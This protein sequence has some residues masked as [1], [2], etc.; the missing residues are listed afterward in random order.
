MR[1][2][3]IHNQVK[4]H[5][6]RVVVVCADDET[7][8]T[9]LAEASQEHIIEPF[10]TG[11]P[12]RIFP[13]LATLGLEQWREKILPSA[14]P[15][16]AAA[17]AFQMVARGEAELVMKGHVPTPLLLKAALRQE[18]GFTTG[19]LL[20]HVAFFEIPGLEKLLCLTDTGMVLRPTFEE[21]ISLIDNA[22]AFE[23]TLGIER[24][25]VAIVS[26]TETP[27]PKMQCSMDA[28]ELM[29]LA[30]AGRFP[31]ADIWGPVDVSIAL[32]PEAAAIKGVPP[33]FSGKTDIWLVPEM[34]GGNI[35][36]KTLIY[37]AKAAAGGVI[38]G[39]KS[40]IILLSRASAPSEKF[41]SIVLAVASCK[42]RE[43]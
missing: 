16:Q 31:N 1:F 15:E 17:A 27:N 39:G 12:A 10:L 42:R 8:L 3:D 13:L 25:V 38:V 18:N 30:Q 22:V 35:L 4:N 36:G 29:K 7:A 9:A 37:F 19:G 11:D 43:S 34:V 21:K 6:A 26:A 28:Q 33:L 41:N 40:A 2:S 5:R 24:P 20:S 32:D 14:S 23:R